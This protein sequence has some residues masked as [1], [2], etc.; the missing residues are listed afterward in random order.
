MRMPGYAAEA[1]LYKSGE[2]F[3]IEGAQIARSDKM[4]VV[5]AWQSEVGD[6][7]NLSDSV[8][9]T[10]LERIRGPLPDRVCCMWVPT[11]CLEEGPD[12]TC[13]KWKGEMK[14]WC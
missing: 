7:R 6:L 3:E 1:S 5:P 13:Y 10:P 11:G 8:G 12:G 2:L 14:C 9:T 4:T